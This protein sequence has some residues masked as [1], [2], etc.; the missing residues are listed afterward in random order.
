MIV[1]DSYTTTPN[2]Y[3]GIK[4]DVGHGC[5]FV[6]SK[7]YTVVACAFILYRED[8]SDPNATH[9]HITAV[10]GDG[11]PTGAD[12]C[13]SVVISYTTLT[14]DVD[15]VTFVDMQFDSTAAL[16]SATK[17]ALYGT[18][19]DDNYNL[20]IRMATP[21]SGGNRLQ[22]ISGV[23]YNCQ[24]LGGYC[25]NSVNFR[26]YEAEPPS[27]GGRKRQDLTLLGVG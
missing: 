18:N 2:D 5:N 9:W 26:T 8:G 1:V 4:L 17:Y 10:D 13:T 15:T 21:G 7:D 20:H 19:D 25:A 24:T 22:S 12:L 27:A 6:A 3:S 11:H 14:I 16:S 23:W